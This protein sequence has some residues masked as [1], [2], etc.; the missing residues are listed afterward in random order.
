[1]AV[2]NN[3]LPAWSRPYQALRCS[4]A[5]L[6]RS[7]L[8]PWFMPISI[9]EACARKGNPQAQPCNCPPVCTA[10]QPQGYLSRVIKFSEVLT[11]KQLHF[12]SRITELGTQVWKASYQSRVRGKCYPIRMQELAHPQDPSGELLSHNTY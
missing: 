6:P 12:T 9:I 4:T 1:M 5:L 2:S 8:Q 11:R 3:T 7:W 10:Q